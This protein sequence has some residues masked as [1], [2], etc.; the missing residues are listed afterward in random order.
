MEPFVYAANQ[1][2]RTASTIYILGLPLFLFDTVRF[3]AESAN[4]AG[5]IRERSVPPACIDTTL[6]IEMAL[7]ISIGLL[8][9]SENHGSNRINSHNVS[10]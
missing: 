7:D 2:L 5:P 8:G 6:T 10:D 1:L 9:T 4:G 3:E